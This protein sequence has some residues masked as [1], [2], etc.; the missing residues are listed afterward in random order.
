MARQ[1]RKRHTEP[2][3]DKRVMSRN[4]VTFGQDS[5]SELW[6]RM[7]AAIGVHGR[8]HLLASAK[9]CSLMKSEGSHPAIGLGSSAELSVLSKR[10]LWPSAIT[11]SVMRCTGSISFNSEDFSKVT[12]SCL[13]GPKEEGWLLRSTSSA[14]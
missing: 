10:Y 2:Y 7:A 5:K 4:T 9:V 13:E 11:W 14:S 3:L 1:S 12:Y 6:V 8:K